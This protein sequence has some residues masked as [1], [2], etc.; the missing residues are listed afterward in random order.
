MDKETVLRYFPIKRS[1]RFY[2]VR[3]TCILLCNNKEKINK[4]LKEL[5]HKDVYKIQKTNE[6]VSVYFKN[7]DRIITFLPFDS[8]RGIRYTSIIIDL[9]MHIDKEIW[10]TLIVPIGIHCTQNNIRFI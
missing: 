10:Q 8:S 5:Q 6:R 4:L 1:P 2:P 3:D 7:G 9:D